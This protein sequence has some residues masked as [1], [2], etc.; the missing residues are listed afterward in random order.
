MLISVVIPLFNKEKYILRAI[1]SILSQ[2]YSYFELIVV[3]DGSTDGS[4][5]V[6]R[7]VTNA[8]VRLISQPNFGVSVAR[9]RGVQESRGDWIAF[10]DADDEYEPCFLEAMVEFIRDHADA[11]LS[12]VGANYYLGS[13][14]NIA[15]NQPREDGV[16]DYFQLFG[17]QRSPNNSSTTA[18]NKKKFM[19]VGGFPE[20]VKQFEDWTTWFKLAFVGT[21]GFI[22]RP[23]GIYHEIEG[24]V[25]RSKR[26]PNGFF[27]DA[28][29]LPK[30]VFD[31]LVEH[32]LSS[33]REREV[34]G[35]INEFSV[36]IA[37][38]LARSGEK[39]LALKMLRFV[40]LKHFTSR[41]SG[42]IGFLL[43]HMAAPQQIKRMYWQCKCGERQGCFRV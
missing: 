17:N 11:D 3:D 15:L 36:N 24:S 28:K 13:R 42:H 6:V 10:L 29:R 9:N 34:R 40:Q 23:L 19:E 43:L 12:M 31:Y 41:R 1:G 16:Y 30:T 33:D 22:N 38:V 25:A 39:K 7:S 5:E 4:V 20:G 18:V 37:G 8:R 35:C 2:T 26:K 14:E 21:F 27:N 32:P